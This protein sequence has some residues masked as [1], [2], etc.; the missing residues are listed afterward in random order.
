MQEIAGM[1]GGVVT[2]LAFV[3]YIISILRSET[4]PNRLSWI[5]WTIIGFLDLWA[6]Y[7][8]GA[9]H[10]IWIPLVYFIGPLLI[11]ILSLRYGKEGSTPI[12]GWCG[13][14]AVIGLL[15]WYFFESALLGLIAFIIVDFFA[16][17][18]TVIKSYLRPWQ[19]NKLAWSLAFVG[20]LI[21]LLAVSQWNLEMALL[22]VYYVFQTGG[23]SFIL[24]FAGESR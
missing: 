10:S 8:L 15:L 4:K 13:V 21:N 24:W 2:G 1:I 23:I 12:D 3:P 18:P 14:G 17:V 9:R 19:E 6:Y 7:S 5:L 22:P 16:M 20:N 11:A